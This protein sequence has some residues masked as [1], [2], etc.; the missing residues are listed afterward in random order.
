MTC[1]L[2]DADAA[3]ESKFGPIKAS[4]AMC[5]SILYADDT[6]IVE[7]HA[8]AAQFF[9][10]EIEK[11]GK[12][13]GLEFN[14]KKL[15]IFAANVEEDLFDSNGIAIKKKDRIIY[16]GSILSANGCVNSEL[17]RR[18]GAANQALG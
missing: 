18:T 3:V 13:Y 11:R 4:I 17:G 8:E 5:R 12:Y 1:L 9:M 16:L 10:E 6:L 14:N 7:I 2:W 15:E